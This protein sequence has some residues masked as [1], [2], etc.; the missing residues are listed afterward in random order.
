MQAARTAKNAIKER[1]QS[2]DEALG[3]IERQFGKGAILSLGDEGAFEPVAAIPT[4]SLALDHA[5]GIG[6]Y[7]R[8]RIVDAAVRWSG[9]RT[10]A[11]Q[12]LG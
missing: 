8:G 4:G 5:L 2:L 3:T 12:A 11:L 9:T 6:G 1:I 7:P 10:R